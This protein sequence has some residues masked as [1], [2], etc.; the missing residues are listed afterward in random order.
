MRSINRRGFTIGAFAAGI[1]AP[2]ILSSRARAAEFT[3]KLASEIPSAHPFV[4]R[5]REASAKILEESGGRFELRVFPDGQLG[6]G[7]DLLS[8]VRSGGVEFYGIG[9]LQLGG[10]VP[11]AQVGSIGFAFKDYNAVWAAM[12][13]DLGRLIHKAIMDTPSLMAFETVW[14]VG[15][16]QITSR[17]RPVN[18]PK[19]LQNFKVR[20][21]AG[22]LWTSLFKALGASPTTMTFAELYTALQS[23]AVDGQENPLAVI[24][25]GRLYEVQKYCAI[26]NHMWS[27]NHIVGNKTFWSSV[28]KDLQDI[29]TKHIN[30]G[31]LLERADIVQADEASKKTMMNA[32]MTFNQPDQAPFRAALVSAGFYEE[33]RKRFGDQVWNTLQ[34]YSGPLS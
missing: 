11:V 21:P 19:D 31:A 27:G 26:T 7:A 34:K 25:A 18:G 1:A 2:A 5:M 22:P 17:D 33:W 15:Y 29:V 4:V 30:A 8:Q 10:F 20:V 23:G 24:S 32:G 9:G 3:G 14:D 13:G 28:P 6:G 16:R 12:D